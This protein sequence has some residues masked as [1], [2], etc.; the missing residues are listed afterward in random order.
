M[1]NLKN[2]LFRLLLVQGKKRTSEKIIFLFLKSLQKNHKKNPK[3][4]IKSAF[5]NSSPLT[6]IKKIRRKRR[7]TKE[8]PIILKKK[9]RIN[10]GIKSIIH[11]SKESLSNSFYHKFL[12]TIVNSS[13]Y[14]SAN[15][16]KKE[17]VHENSFIKKK[18]SNYRW[19]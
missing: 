19:F 11:Y 9:L 12:T 8:F 16:L 17:L 15:V 7:Q 6:Q 10:L 13:K 3:L 2:Q 14:Q 18:Y 5:I 1:T 4:L